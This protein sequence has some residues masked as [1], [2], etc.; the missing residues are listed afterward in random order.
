MA[1][2]CLKQY[3]HFLKGLTSLYDE[4]KARYVSH[5]LDADEFKPT[6]KNTVQALFPLIVPDIPQKHK[7]SIIA[8]LTSVRFRLPRK[9]TTNHNTPSQLYR[10]QMLLITQFTQ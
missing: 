9:I 5:Y 4:E 6:K 2:Y 8:M 10:G 1:E 7:D 3:S